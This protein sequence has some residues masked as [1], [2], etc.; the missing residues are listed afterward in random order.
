MMLA[1][2]EMQSS[3]LVVWLQQMAMWCSISQKFEV[4]NLGLM[5]ESLVWKKKNVVLEENSCNTTGMEGHTP[6]CVVA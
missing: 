1:R 5:T 6:K 3:I 4:G 2:Y